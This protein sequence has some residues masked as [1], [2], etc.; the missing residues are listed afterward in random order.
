M[1]TQ[2]KTATSGWMTADA[3]A[4]YLGVSRAQFYNYVR[5]G[6]VTPDASLPGARGKRRYPRYRAASL[7]EAVVRMND[8]KAR[9]LSADAISAAKRKRSA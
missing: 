8:P 5:R 7:D 3:A 9:I 4:S 2:S 1:P 6:W